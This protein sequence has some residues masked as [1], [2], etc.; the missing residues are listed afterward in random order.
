[1]GFLI[2]LITTQDSITLQ[3]S[4]D[5]VHRVGDQRTVMSGEDPMMGGHVLFGVEAA[6]IAS[7]NLIPGPWVKYFEDAKAKDVEAVIQFQKTYYPLFDLLFQYPITSYAEFL[8]SSLFHVT[9]TLLLH[10]MVI[11]ISQ[12]RLYCKISTFAILTA[13]SI[14]LSEIQNSSRARVF[15][16]RTIRGAS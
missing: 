14:R 4:V 13:S 5:I 3:V 15:F 2:S 11:I 6:I 9:R 12:A 1:M 10:N 8:H 7:A 16:I